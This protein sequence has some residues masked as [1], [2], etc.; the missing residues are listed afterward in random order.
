M[1]RV[2]YHL[3]S[4]LEWANSSPIHYPR[5]ETV[6]HMWCYHGIL[7]QGASH[8]VI[9]ESFRSVDTEILRGHPHFIQLPIQHRKSSRQ[10]SDQF[11][12]VVA[13]ILLLQ[14]VVLV[15]HAVMRGESLR[16]IPREQ[17]T[18]LTL[19]H[20]Q[21]MLIWTGSMESFRI[22]VLLSRTH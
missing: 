19:V 2:P 1:S 22:R 3:T 15:I 11:K 13:Y 21:A 17:D 16:W 10:S 12:Q 7:T 8:D 6:R 9:Y 14:S 20:S 5:A 18:I 4:L